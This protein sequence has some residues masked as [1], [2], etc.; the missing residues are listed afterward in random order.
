MEVKLKLPNAVCLFAFLP[1]IP[2]TVL[3]VEKFQQQNFL[4]PLVS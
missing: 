2:V 3:K 4:L 1:G